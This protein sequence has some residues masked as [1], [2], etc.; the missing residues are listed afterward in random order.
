MTKLGF[1]LYVNQPCFYYWRKG[2]KIVIVVVYINGII[3][4]TGNCND[5]IIE[6]KRPLAKKFN[7]KDLGEPKQF[8]GIK[9]P[10]L[11]EIERR[12]SLN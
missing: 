1:Q 11:K 2:D 9:L 12:E 3:I 8:L 10:V 6:T 5:K 7:I 4:I